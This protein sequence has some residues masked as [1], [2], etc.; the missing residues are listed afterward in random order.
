MH[1]RSRRLLVVSVLVPLL[2]ATG[3]PAASAGSGSSSRS[4][5]FKHSLRIDNRLFSL[6]PGTQFVFDGTVTDDEG[7]HPH[8]I[9]F[10]VTDMVKKV[11]GVWTRVVWDQDVDDGELAEAELAFFAQDRRKNVL[12]MGEYPEEYENGRFVGAPSTWLSGQ[13]RARAGIL[14]PG[15]PRVGQRFVQGRAPA[16]DFFDVGVVKS[17][18]TRT[19]APVGCF[20]HATLI[21]ETAPLAP[22]D[23]KQLKYYVR[24]VGLVRIGAVGGD[25]RE[26]M[27]LTRVRHLGPVGMARARAAAL[28]LERRA[29]RVSAPYRHTPPMR[30][31]HDDECGDDD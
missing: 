9:V 10:T 1:I 7:R 24:G 6:Q 15:H 12:T 26:V 30:R 5:R 28:K 22:E 20:R 19:C 2:V 4:D 16:V 31:C 29:Y 13:A 3:S 23:G 27:T 18:H 8:R 21:E 17:R 11:D 14:V 25:A